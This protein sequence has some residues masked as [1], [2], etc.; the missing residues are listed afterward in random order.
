MTVREA[1]IDVGALN[2]KV[3][4]VRILRDL[5]F[6]VANLGLILC[7]T[8]LLLLI[9]G[10]VGEI[11]ALFPAG[12][13]LTGSGVIVASFW[14]IALRNRISDASSDHQEIGEF[15]EGASDHAVSEDVDQSESKAEG[16]P[17]AGAVFGPTVQTVDVEG[18]RQTY[19]V[20]WREPFKAKE[21]PYF[22]L[23]WDLKREGPGYLYWV[24][25]ELLEQ[26][27]TALSPLGEFSCSEERTW[28]AVAEIP[29]FHEIVRYDRGR[30]GGETGYP[31]VYDLLKTCYVLVGLDE[32]EYSKRIESG[33]WR[34]YFRIR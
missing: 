16:P 3:R 13:I 27:K 4:R 28:H 17:N 33:H 20:L 26:A 11:S 24:S 7:A 10:R 21:D 23:S 29:R 34:L 15:A 25:R 32:A 12:V 19:T 6:G 2:E 9:V 1:D 8:G 5:G 30:I 31:L 18:V 22:V 14:T